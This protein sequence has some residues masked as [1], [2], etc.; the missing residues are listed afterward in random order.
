MNDTKKKYIVVR[1]G[2]Q[3][4]DV[5]YDSATDPEALKEQSFWKK[6]ATVANDG[7]MVTIIEYNQGKGKHKPLV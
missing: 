7:S 1:D 2:V 4:S 3:V 6:T 5:V